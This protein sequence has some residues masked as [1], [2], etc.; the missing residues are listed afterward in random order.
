MVRAPLDAKRVG[1][2]A[3]DCMLLAIAGW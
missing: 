3:S 1:A 2:A